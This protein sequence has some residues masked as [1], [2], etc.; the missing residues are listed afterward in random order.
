MHLKCNPFQGHS[1]EQSFHPI[2]DFKQVKYNTKSKICVNIT[3]NVFIYLLHNVHVNLKS[4]NSLSLVKAM[5]RLF[6]IKSIS[7][8]T[9]IKTINNLSLLKAKISR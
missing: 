5:N 2:Q 8:L 6:L 1:P 3:K 9:H 4:V 7:N